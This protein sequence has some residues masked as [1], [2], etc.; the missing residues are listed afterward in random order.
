MKRRPERSSS[1]SVSP[2]IARARPRRRKI[3]RKVLLG[4]LVIGAA[5]VSIKKAY[6]V[7]MHQPFFKLREVSVGG[8]QW[9]SEDHIRSL[10]QA[11]VGQNVFSVDLAAEA[12]RIQKDPMVETVRLSR[13]L[14]DRIL[15]SITER[16]PVAFLVRERLYGVDAL[17]VLLPPFPPDRMPD[18]P[19]FTA[20]GSDTTRP[21]G[22]IRSSRLQEG[23]RFINEMRKRD[24]D[25]IEVISEIH[26][27]D[28]EGLVLCLIDGGM[29]VKWGWGDFERKI[30]P[31]R[32]ALSQIP[33]KNRP[34]RLLDV[35][36][37]GQ[38]V[39]RF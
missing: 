18:L 27:G 3:G 33:S 21:G 26:L 34:P 9:I 11:E 28:R 15:V 7:V 8:N 14:P 6:P 35:R 10:M 39:A 1:R 24:P 31:L 36:F 22:V 30:G 13:N 23:I 38:V 32:A 19:I 16:E 20:I 37:E 12:E 29:K 5:I 2:M 25:L 17:G 4:A